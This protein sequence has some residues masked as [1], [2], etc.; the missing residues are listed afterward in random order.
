MPLIKRVRRSFPV[1]NA[2][3]AG[4]VLSAFKSHIQP[5]LINQDPLMM[6][7]LLTPLRKALHDQPSALVLAD[8]ALYDIL[9]KT[10]GLPLY[11]IIGGYRSC[12]KT[13]VTIG[14][15][16]VDEMARRAK[17]LAEQG[18][19]ALKIKGGLDLDQDIEKILRIRG[20]IGDKIELRFDANQ[21]YSVDESIKFVDATRPAE[22]ELLEQPTPRGEIDLLCRL[23]DKV[24]IPVMADESLVT[25]RDVF[26]LA[27]HEVVDMVNVKLMK[28]GGLSEA[29]QINAIARAAKLDVMVGCMDEAAYGIA[30]GLH[31]ALARPNVAYADLDGHLDLMNDPTS[32]AVILKDGILYPTGKPGIGFEY[33]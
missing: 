3:N 19:Q 9:G 24:P 6:S 18:F 12:I 21:G 1:V 32:G 30:A 17:M 13:S 2:K 27:K 20:A 5:A 14:I 29:L 25:M 22:I 23:T 11:K 33:P 26:R 15:L 28:V 31:L 4:T 16:P 8:M 10:A 7:Y